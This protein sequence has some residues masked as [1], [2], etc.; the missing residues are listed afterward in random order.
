MSVRIV[1]VGGPRDGDELTVVGASLPHVIPDDI[2]GQYRP[3]IS[4]AEEAEQD[5]KG[6][7]LYSWSPPE[8]RS[9]G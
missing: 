7:Y 1:F 3:R 5:H 8:R 4:H 2:Q 9:A 6:R